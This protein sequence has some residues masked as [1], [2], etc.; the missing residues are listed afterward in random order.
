MSLCAD[1][2]RWVQPRFAS[3]FFPAARSG[4]SGSAFQTSQTGLFNWC[5]HPGSD[6]ANTLA[7]ARIDVDL[8]QRQALIE[9][10]QCDWLR[11]VARYERYAR[12]HKPDSF[13]H[14]LRHRGI[15]IKAHKLWSYHLETMAPYRK[16]WSEAMLFAAIWFLKR[17]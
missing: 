1:N 4:F 7:W 11:K 3:R 15:H 9:E 16:I 2:P 10:I 13:V 14:S 6:E 8:D 12:A 5:G 17:N